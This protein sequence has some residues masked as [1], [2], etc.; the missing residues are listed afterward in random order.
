M[1]RFL[2]WF[3]RTRPNKPT[4]A[5]GRRMVRLQLEH[6]GARLVPSTL[7]LSSAIHIN[8]PTFVERDWYSIDQSTHQVVEFQG[9]SRKNLGGPSAFQVSAS[10]DPKTGFGEVYALDG[11]G[12]LWRCDSLGVW[13]NNFTGAYKG[14]SATRDGGV[15]ALTMDVKQVF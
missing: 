8:H 11:S 1:K 6:L 14:I 3:S 7:G 5:C 15:F 9:T 4:G 12:S 13:W 2:D 10:V